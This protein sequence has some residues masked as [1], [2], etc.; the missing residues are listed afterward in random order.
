MPYMDAKYCEKCDEH[1]DRASPVCPS[2]QSRDYYLALHKKHLLA[3][4]IIQALPKCDRA[5][6]GLPATKH[7]IF[8]ESDSGIEFKTEIYRCDKHG[9]S[10]DL[11]VKDLNYAKP[12]RD[13]IKLIQNEI[14][15]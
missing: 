15:Y 3:Q 7:E 8:D 4:E 11:E 9:F 1:Y 5:N 12:L 2:C 14:K 10:N 6:C 13:Y